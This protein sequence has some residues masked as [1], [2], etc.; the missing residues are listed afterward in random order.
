M[1][2]M[3]MLAVASL[4][5]LP[6]LSVAADSEYSQET[7]AYCNEQAQLAGFESEQEMNE[8][9]RDCQESM[10]LAT[11]EILSPEQ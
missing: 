8:Y 11:G 9:I 6:N 7:T 3:M 10:G 5:M 2:Y 1:K 4:L